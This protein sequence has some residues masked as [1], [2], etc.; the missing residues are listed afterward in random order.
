LYLVLFVPFPNESIYNECFALLQSRKNENWLRID[1]FDHSLKNYICHNQ[2]NVFGHTEFDSY[3]L[4]TPV[5]NQSK[6]DS[7]TLYTPVKNQSKNDS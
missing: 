1:N 5:K 3:T 4:Y 2:A 6:N 7:Y